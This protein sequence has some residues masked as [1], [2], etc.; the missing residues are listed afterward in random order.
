MVRVRRWAVGRQDVR[1][2][3][4]PFRERVVGDQSGYRHEAFREEVSHDVIRVCSMCSKNA[5]QIARM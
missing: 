4:V 5:L 3:V 2:G 1:V